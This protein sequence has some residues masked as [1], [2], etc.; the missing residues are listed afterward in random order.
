MAT[1]NLSRS[2]PLAEKKP[3]GRPKHPLMIDAEEAM[4]AIAVLDDVVN[5]AMRAK[6]KLVEGIAMYERAARKAA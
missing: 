2:T 4:N 5:L 3:T 1:S 6:R